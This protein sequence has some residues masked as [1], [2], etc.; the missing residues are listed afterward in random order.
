MVRVE[1]K[2]VRPAS[3]GTRT[4]DAMHEVEIR[5]PYCAKR[6]MVPVDP[7]AE[8]V[9]TSVPC[10]DCERVMLVVVDIDED[11]SPIVTVESLLPT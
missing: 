11:G 7:A 8:E 6:F 10:P 2:P 9:R 1:A 3:A 4:E 5:C